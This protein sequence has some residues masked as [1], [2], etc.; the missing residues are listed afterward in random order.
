MNNISVY[1]L[2]LI[3]I[4]CTFAITQFGNEEFHTNKRINQYT[5]NNNFLEFKIDNDINIY[6]MEIPIGLEI[7][8]NDTIDISVEERNNK[9]VDIEEIIINGKSIWDIGNPNRIKLEIK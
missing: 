9:I 1:L 2:G 4:I 3:F 5:I 6:I 7:K 8:N